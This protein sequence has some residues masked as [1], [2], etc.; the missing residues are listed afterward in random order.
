MTADARFGNSAAEVPTTVQARILCGVRNRLIL[1]LQENVAWNLERLWNVRAAAQN[2][3]RWGDQR[4]CCACCGNIKK[5]E[6]SEDLQSANSFAFNVVGAWQ[7]GDR[8]LGEKE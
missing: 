6:I 4:L 3:G 7:V 5:N 8:I 1:R 2:R